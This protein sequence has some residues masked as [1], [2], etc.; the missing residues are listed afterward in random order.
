MPPE[1]EPYFG[2]EDRQEARRIRV[3][4]VERIARIHSSFSPCLAAI[5]PKGDFGQSWKE[6]LAQKLLML[7]RKH[8]R[9]T[10][11]TSRQRLTP[12]ILTEAAE[13]T[14]LRSSK[15]RS[16]GCDEVALVVTTGAEG[17]VDTG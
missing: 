1:F 12:R 7:A 5:V 9:C 11:A 6:N 14:V 2:E 17:V 10:A 4:G 3:P 15:P 8:G 13:T 16:D